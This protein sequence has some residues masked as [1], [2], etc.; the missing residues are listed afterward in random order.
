MTLTH[1]RSSRFLVPPWEILLQGF[2]IAKKATLEFIDQF[3]ENAE[4]DD[5]ELL[6]CV[7]RTSLRTKLQE[8][9]ADQL[10]DI[11]VEAVLTIRKPDQMLD[12]FMVE[13]SSLFLPLNLI[14][15][16]EDSCIYIYVSWSIFKCGKW[17]QSHTALEVHVRDLTEE[18]SVIKWHT[19]PTSYIEYVTE[20]CF[21]HPL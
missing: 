16:R 17:Q 18:Y 4:P 13:I 14:T 5:R 15:L 21:L 12:L 10:T 11:V 8:K 1:V 6:K 7:A 2:E 20:T 19:P 3:K 9:L